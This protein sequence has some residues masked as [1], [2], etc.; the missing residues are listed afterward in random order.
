MIRGFAE[1]LALRRFSNR[2]EDQVFSDYWISK[3]L[4]SSGLVHLAERGF[5]TL[6]LR[7]VNRV[8]SPYQI[9]ALGCLVSIHH[10]YPS[11]PLGTEVIPI[12]SRLHEMDQN[13][14]THS[15]L[16][17]SQAA[18]EIQLSSGTRA[19]NDLIQI[20][21]ILK[22]S[23]ILEPLTRALQSIQSKESQATLK[24]FDD[25]F[26]QINY[27]QTSPHSVAD[28]E[29]LELVKPHLD[30]IHLLAARTAFELGQFSVAV[31]HYQAIGTRS[32]ARVQAL[33]ELSWTYLAQEKY[34]DAIGTTVSL[35]LGPMRH[36]F[37][38]EAPMIMAIALNEMCRFPESMG[39]IQ[40]FKN[41]YRE[42]YFWLKQHASSPR[43]ASDEI[44]RQVFSFAKKLPASKIPSQLGS[45]WIGSAHF[46]HHQEILNLMIQEKQQRNK[47]SEIG[48]HEQRENTRKILTE[49]KTL[50]RLLD[51]LILKSKNHE[52]TPAAGR[53]TLKS[54]F[55]TL[56]EDLIHLKRMRFASRIWRKLVKQ[57][58]IRAS[59]IRRTIIQKIADE[60]LLANQ[61]MLRKLDEIAENNELIE[62]EILNGASDDLIWQNAHPHFQETI[63]KIK[64]QTRM[65]ESG[66]V[67]NWGSTHLASEGSRE[68][69]SEIW[70]DEIG[71]L[72]ADLGDQCENRDKY[73]QILAKE[74]I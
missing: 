15:K 45:E 27:F 4:Y 69:S 60:V 48:S 32:N 71:S 39:A 37:A 38:P 21:S 62:V 49:A 51:E 9:A 50:H 68:A 57:D 36:T 19:K 12:L 7:P 47:I 34:S 5:S 59:E 41:H 8:T 67:W 29:D 58:E 56:K 55:K 46:I 43:L 26:N 33:I 2:T 40:A 73:L 64:S 65:I 22:D 42:S 70:E 13:R 16:I 20:Q 3:I 18:F 31:Q 66:K 11:I 28:R 17:L 1:A 44:Y 35:Q 74:K 14:T 25:F 52:I 6:I 54:S 53:S 30:A 24:S 10:H 63:E 61:R 23:R 72:S